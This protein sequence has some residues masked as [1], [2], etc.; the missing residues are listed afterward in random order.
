MEELDRAGAGIILANIFPN[1]MLG[2]R[3]CVSPVGKA[4]CLPEGRIPVPV[5]F[6]LFPLPGGFRKGS[7]VWFPAVSTNQKIA[8]PLSANQRLSLGRLESAGGERAGSQA[9]CKHCQPV[10]GGGGR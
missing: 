6:S 8:P 3:K 10:T 5:G 9:S 2:M 4:K 1:M 7:K